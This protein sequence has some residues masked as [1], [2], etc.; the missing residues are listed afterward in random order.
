MQTEFSFKSHVSLL[1]WGGDHL[2]EEV[3]K[4]HQL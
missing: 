4:N 3:L 2:R 1:T